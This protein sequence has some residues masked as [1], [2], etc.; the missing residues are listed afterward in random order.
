MSLSD[1]LFDLYSNS[2]DNS[3]LDPRTQI[4]GLLLFSLAPIF[5][6]SMFIL[7]MYLSIPLFIIITFNCQLFIFKRVRIGILLLL[8]ACSFIYF[9]GQ[10]QNPQHVEAIAMVK[11][12]LRVL[13]ILSASIIFINNTSISQ[14]ISSLEKL[15]LPFSIIF[16]L[17]ITIRF[18]PHMLR[19]TELICDNA[20]AKGLG[21]R[22]LIIHPY[23]SI[24]AF[25][26]PLV[27]RAIKKADA[28]GT[29]ATMRGFGAPIQRTSLDELVFSSIDYFF[30]FILLIFLITSL[31]FDRWITILL[32]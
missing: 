18:F 17:S 8:L 27:I 26:F 3:R 11:V 25:L 29:S 21:Y 22:Q 12:L 32:A 31:W 20:R 13:I 9:W 5:V 7:Y 19:E 6:N 30:L 16:S 4:I 10:F 28:L 23:Q 1:R 2:K 24:R 14:F 15:H